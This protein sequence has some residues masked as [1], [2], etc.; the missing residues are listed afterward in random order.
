MVVSS[1]D[2]EGCGGCSGPQERTQVSSRSDRIGLSQK[3]SYLLDVPNYVMYENYGEECPA[4]FS[5]L[6]QGDGGRKASR[7]GNFLKVRIQALMDVE[8]SFEEPE[9]PFNATDDDHDSSLGSD[10]RI[11]LC[12]VNSLTSPFTLKHAW[13]NKVGVKIL[14]MQQFRISQN[15]LTALQHLFGAKPGKD[16]PNVWNKMDVVKIDD[17]SKAAVMSED[18]SSVTLNMESVHANLAR[19]ERGLVG[20]LIEGRLPFLC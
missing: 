4:I 17:V 18:G 14:L 1:D 3:S 19:L 16:L 2:D 12:Q 15:L 6:R 5:P 13:E 7:N 9:K 20:K 10:P 8:V 11:F